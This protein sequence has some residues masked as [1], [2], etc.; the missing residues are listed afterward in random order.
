MIIREIAIIAQWIFNLQHFG[1]FCQYSAACWD[2][3]ALNLRLKLLQAETKPQQ[4]RNQ[5]YS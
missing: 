3:G 4:T 1:R 5:S 2:E